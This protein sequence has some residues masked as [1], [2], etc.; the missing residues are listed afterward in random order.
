MTIDEMKNKIDEILSTTTSPE[1]AMLLSDLKRD[2]ELY[3]SERDGGDFERDEKI[4]E[5]EKDVLN[6]DERIHDLEES[7]RKIVEKYSERVIFDE[8]KEDG[9]KEKTETVEY[10][11]LIKKFETV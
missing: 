11:G 3:K 2:L 7:N 5:L 1:A 10:D 6:R 4:S 8:K 9:E